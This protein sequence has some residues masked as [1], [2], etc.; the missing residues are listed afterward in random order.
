M[1]RNYRLSRL[2]SSLSDEARH[3]LIAANPAFDAAARWGELDRALKIEQRTR[4]SSVDEK[5][6]RASL[7]TV[8]RRGIQPPGD[9]HLVV[10]VSFL[11]LFLSCLVFCA[12]TDRR[13]TRLLGVTI[14]QQYRD[15]LALA[16][17]SRL[18]IEDAFG[19]VLRDSEAWGTS[20]RSTLGHR[21]QHSAVDGRREAQAAAGKGEFTKTKGSSYPTSATVV[22]SCRPLGFLDAQA[23]TYALERTSYSPAC[24][25]TFCLAHRLIASYSPWPRATFHGLVAG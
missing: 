14:R 16:F 17:E 6:C 15:L 9:Q 20:L 22:R 4:D 3:Q 21:N 5:D 24:H 13:S 10:W 19:K 23:A 12:T 1:P 11:P 8:G 2:P 18:R 25:S 7:Q